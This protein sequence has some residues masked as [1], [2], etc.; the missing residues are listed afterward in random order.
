MTVVKVM[1]IAL[2]R[3]KLERKLNKTLFV[4]LPAVRMD[5]FKYDKCTRDIISIID[6]Y[7]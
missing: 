6:I 2:R 3:P 5:N 4:S 1:T 7:A